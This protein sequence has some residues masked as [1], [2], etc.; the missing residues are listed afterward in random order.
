MKT[1]FTECLLL[2][3]SDIKCLFDFTPLFPVVIRRY[4]VRKLDNDLLTLLIIL[5]LTK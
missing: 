3:G 5:R 4:D 2:A 1:K